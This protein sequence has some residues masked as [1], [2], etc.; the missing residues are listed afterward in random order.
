MRTSIAE[1]VQTVCFGL[2]IGPWSKIY[3]QNT[4]PEKETFYANKINRVSG[5]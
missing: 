1:I 3:A 5:S 4:N 2:T